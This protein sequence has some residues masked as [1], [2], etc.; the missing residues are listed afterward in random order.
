MVKKAWNLLNLKKTMI[1]NQEIK[2]KNK[3]AIRV[4]TLK[5]EPDIILTHIDLGK[6]KEYFHKLTFH[7]NVPD[8]KSFVHIKVIDA[9]KK[10]LAE[11][12]SN[13][14][15][16]VL[17]FWST[18][19]WVNI[20]IKGFLDQLNMYYYI[21]RILQES[22]TEVPIDPSLESLLEIDNQSVDEFWE[23]LPRLSMWNYLTRIPG[24]TAQSHKNLLIKNHGDVFLKI[25][26]HDCN[27][28]MKFE[29]S[30]EI[31]MILSF[32]L[33]INDHYQGPYN[34]IHETS[35]NN[36]DNDNVNNI[37]NVNNDNDVNRKVIEN[38]KYKEKYF[39]LIETIETL[40]K[41]LR[42]LDE[43][44]KNLKEERMRLIA[45]AELLNER[46]LPDLDNNVYYGETIAKIE[47][48]T[49]IKNYLIA[50]LLKQYNYKQIS[51]KLLA[52]VSA[53]ASASTNAITET[54]AT[55]TA[56]ATAKTAL[57]TVAENNKGFIILERFNKGII[58]L[59]NMIGKDVLKID[60]ELQKLL[61]IKARLV[62][63]YNE[64]IMNDPVIDDFN[65]LKNKI[66]EV[67]ETINKNI[68]LI[69]LMQDQIAMSNLQKWSVFHL[70]L[71]NIIEDKLVKLYDKANENKENSQ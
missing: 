32:L 39:G 59:Y 4:S 65:A 37:N 64:Q 61:E 10:L 33:R 16:L 48:L 47:A 44:N 36:D 28:K 35:P 54:E 7:L 45:R 41:K 20:D 40:M 2:I 27:S 24:L 26:H 11:G 46:V 63:T 38:L 55:A 34:I 21:I 68:E 69:M 9:D 31:A 14:D 53:S 17:N 66:T 56:T 15:L 71:E 51:E 60:E 57:S 49:S 70:Y 23:E 67:T 43:N 12:R 19:Q 18:T 58:S 22:S 25:I 1:T 62:A 42:E 8:Q 29:P 6:D 5:P 13:S 50:D 3:V 30:R 52:S